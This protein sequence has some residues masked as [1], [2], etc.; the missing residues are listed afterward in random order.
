MWSCHHLLTIV[1]ADV[2]YAGDNLYFVTEQCHTITTLGFFLFLFGYLFYTVHLAPTNVHTINVC[3]KCF[4]NEHL[5]CE[6]V[7]IYNNIYI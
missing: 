2:F 5:S 7:Y 6:I 4:N 1:V 3:N